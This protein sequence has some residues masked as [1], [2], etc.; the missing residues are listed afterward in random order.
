MDALWEKDQYF[1]VWPKKFKKKL[2][3]IKESFQGNA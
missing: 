2:G 3:V 1:S